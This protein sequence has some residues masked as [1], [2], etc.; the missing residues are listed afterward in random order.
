MI[1]LERRIA[2]LFRAVLSALRTPSTCAD[3]TPVQIR[4]GKNGLTMHASTPEITIVYTDPA[5]T[6]NGVFNFPLSRFGEFKGAHQRSGGHR[7]PEAPQSLG[8]RRLE[9]Q[10]P[11]AGTGIRAERA[12]AGHETARTAQELHPAAVELPVRR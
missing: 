7:L 6:G 12:G 3:Q 9:R 10:R 8:G 2:W 1:V 11:N 4:L 5:Q